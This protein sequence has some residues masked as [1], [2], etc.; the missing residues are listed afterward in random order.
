MDH[1]HQTVVGY[2]N[3][4]KY[5]LNHFIPPL[6]DAKQNVGNFLNNLAKFVKREHYFEAGRKNLIERF[7]QSVAEDG[8]VPIP[9]REI[10]LTYQII[11]GIFDQIFSTAD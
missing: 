10:L 11:D 3:N 7:Y 4:Y 5:Y 2:Q 6:I 1:E 9:Y 8:P